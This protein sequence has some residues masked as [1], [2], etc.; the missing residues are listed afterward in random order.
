MIGPSGV[1]PPGGDVTG[2]GAAAIV[3]Q[4]LQRVGDSSLGPGGAYA[5]KSDL[6]RRLRGRTVLF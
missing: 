2:V 5:E 6:V 1:A 4:G 3:Q